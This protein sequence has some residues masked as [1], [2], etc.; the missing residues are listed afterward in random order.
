MAVLC[1]AAAAVLKCGIPNSFRLQIW[2]LITVRGCRCRV[3]AATQQ[4]G[5]L[6]EVRAILRS[7]TLR[8]FTRRVVVV[9]ITEGLAVDATIL[10]R[11]LF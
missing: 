7:L 1:S 3:A 5:L 9:E 2:R 8:R 6:G 10:W 4:P 11:R